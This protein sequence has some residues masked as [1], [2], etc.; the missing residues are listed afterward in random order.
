MKTPEEICAEITL[1]TA[2]Q[3]EVE[4][5]LGMNPFG[6]FVKLFREV[7]KTKVDKLTMRHALGSDYLCEVCD[8]FVDAVYKELIVNHVLDE[9]TAVLKEVC[10]M[11]PVATECDQYVDQLS[12]EAKAFV[13]ANFVSRSA[14]FSTVVCW[15]NAS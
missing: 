8:G 14:F 4:S 10:S 6:R 9:V 11:T 12:G 5:R 7:I 1:C 3:T 13:K 15:P 2:L